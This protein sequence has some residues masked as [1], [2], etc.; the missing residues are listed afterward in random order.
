MTDR[1]RVRYAPSPTGA[2]HVGNVRTAI[3]TWLFARRNG[4]DFIIRVE[5]TDQNRNVEGSIEMLLETL[6]WLGLDWD[7]GPDVGGPFGPYYQ[8]QRLGLYNEAADEL[9]ATGHAYRCFC[10]AERLAELRR[11]R[12]QQDGSSGY[13]GRCRDMDSDERAELGGE[14]VPAVVRF[15]MPREGTTT[16]V[17]MIH[18]EV[19][20]ENRLIDD[21]VMLRS[22]GFP[23]Y[24]LANVVDDHH[25]RISHVMRGDDW[26]SSSPRH[27][28]LYAALGWP[29]PHFAHLPMIL[30][31]DRTKLGKR[32]GASSVLEYR[33]MGYLPQT[34]VNFLSLL[35]WSL[36]DRTDIISRADLIAN[37]SIR[38]IS[39]AGAVF[40]TE[41][42]NWM[43]GAYIRMQNVEELADALL[44]YWR[45][46]PPAEIPE[47]PD[48]HRVLAMAPLVQERLKEL[49]EAAPRLS[50]FFKD[51]PSY[52]SEDL[53]QK[54]MDPERTRR[55]LEAA[56]EMM[57]PLGD[58]SAAT[59]EQPLRAL[60][61]ELGV[62]VGQLFGSLRIATT[63]LRVAP[64]L[65][66]T[67][68]VLGR[69]RTLRDIRAAIN[70]L[71]EHESAQLM[72]SD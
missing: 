9:V 63:G 57:E 60:A 55:A 15:R 53:V 12:T 48:R 37:F 24:H 64:P 44:D 30:A 50:F 19:T 51:A 56:L 16:L 22:N 1:V 65:F 13:D 58:F 6:S 3:F 67:M 36:D 18:G 20:F 17:D 2:T 14:G 42:L 52:D 54:G 35:G 26:L 49:R 5:D 69:E 31:P 59:L 39:K 11:S 28:R 4:G 29:A 62:K 70:R 47:L 66:E 25:M 32:H 10:S 46:Y 7:E 71:A 23:T 41:K 27:V 38:R 43:N 40:N 72:P 8:S 34:M 21:F 45:R 33:E 61:K 68:E